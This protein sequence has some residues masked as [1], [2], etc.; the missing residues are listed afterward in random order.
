MTNR[1]FFSL[2]ALALATALSLSVSC[3]KEKSSWDESFNVSGVILPEVIETTLG[4]NLEFGFVGGHG[5]VMGDEIVFEGTETFRC[6]IVSV[7]DDRFS[8]VLGDMT[9]DLYWK[10]NNYSFREYLQEMGATRNLLI[11]QTIGNHDHSMYYP[12]DDK[13]VKDYTREVS[14][15]YYSFNV[16]GVHCVVLDNVECTN[17]V[18]TTDGKGNPC[19][20]RAYTA[21]IVSKEIQWLQSDLAQVPTTTP[22]VVTMHIP[23]YNPDGSFRMGS[24]I[25]SQFESI[26]S[27]YQTVHLFTGH[28]TV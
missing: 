11:Y 7:S 14:P 9:W 16:G 26:L 23:M 19:Y 28:I 20:E 18:R 5:P 8:F 21:N 4:A 27:Q 24:A 6:A 2:T 17:S 10:T 1:L 3:K 12:G 25:S 13:T 22:L 15:N